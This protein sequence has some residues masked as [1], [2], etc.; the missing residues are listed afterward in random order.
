[1]H[2]RPNSLGLIA[3]VMSVSTTIIENVYT[4]RNKRARVLRRTNSFTITVVDISA[5]EA[6]RVFIEAAHGCV[7]SAEIYSF[8]ANKT[9][10]A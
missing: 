10:T 3:F 7:S 4:C 8:A 6:L 9:V 1:M 5:T 2:S